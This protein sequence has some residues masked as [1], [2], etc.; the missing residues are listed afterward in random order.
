MEE[1]CDLPGAQSGGLSLKE[2]DEGHAEITLSFD[3]AVT[4]D[5]RTLFMD[6]VHTHLRRALEETVV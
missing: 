5:T 3:G 2:I 1:C 4:K 6:Y